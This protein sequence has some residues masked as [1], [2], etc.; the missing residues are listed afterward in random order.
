[1]V[2]TNSNVSKPARAESRERYRETVRR[3]RRR[4]RRRK[5][6]TETET[7]RDKEKSG[8]KEPDS[9]TERCS[10]KESGERKLN[11]GTKIIECNGN[12]NHL[13][14]LGFR[15]YLPLCTTG[16][17]TISI[18]VACHKPGPHT[19]GYLAGVHC[20]GQLELWQV[21]ANLFA[22]EVGLDS[23]GKLGVANGLSSQLGEGDRQKLRR[24]RER[25][26]RESVCVFEC[27]CVCVCVTARHRHR[28]RDGEKE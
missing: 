8:K 3:R 13:T 6:E 1:M 16:G 20:H 26:E 28:L 18:C 17:E 25:R 22:F 19:Q 23:R 10:R 24:E 21:V 27:V 14:A 7:D 15:L 12:K 5:R 9:Q 2:R 11:V 4:R